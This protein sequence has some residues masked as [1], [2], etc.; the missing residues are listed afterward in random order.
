[1]CVYICL[2][3]P[4]HTYKCMNVNMCHSLCVMSMTI[5]PSLHLSL[6]K[7]MVVNLCVNHVQ[8][9]EVPPPPTLTHVGTL[10]A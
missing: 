5:S 3:A 8:H 9:S 2:C 10:T 1:M 4:L 6:W 7:C